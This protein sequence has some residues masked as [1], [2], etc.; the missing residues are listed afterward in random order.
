MD[1]GY[2]RGHVDRDLTSDGG[3]IWFTAATEGVKADGIDLRMEG[4]Q[5]DRFR[6]NPVILFGHNSW[7]R[8]NLPIGRATDVWVEGKRLRIGIEFDQE[9][10][11]ARTIERKIRAKFLN[12]V[13]IGFDVQSWEKPGMNHWNG[14]I[15]TKWELLE[16]SVVPVPM[17]EKATV[18]SGR[19]LHDENLRAFI[20]EQVVKGIKEHFEHAREIGQKVVDSVKGFENHSVNTVD[21]SKVMASFKFG[22]DK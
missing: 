1:R 19:S 3:P 8:Q 2:M 7:G 14:G 10:D 18:E 21:A 17:D 13:S 11:F 16:T 6:D 20:A 9:D 12:A 5:L 15:A 4:A 22:E